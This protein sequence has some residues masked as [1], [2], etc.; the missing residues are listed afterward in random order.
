MVR[1]KVNTSFMIVLPSAIG[2][3]YFDSWKAREEMQSRI[4]TVCGS[5]LGTSMPMADLPG[6]GAMMRIPD[7][8]AIDI[9]I[10]SLRF[11]TRLI[12]VPLSNT[13]SKSV[14]VGPTVAE[15][16]CISMP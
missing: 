5:L 15:I 14:I 6:I 9:A 16:D 12:L 4:D 11:F 2:S 7:F 8:E 3:S 13:I 1:S 10:S